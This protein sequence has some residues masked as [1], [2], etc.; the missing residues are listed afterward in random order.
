[1]RA[2]A[3]IRSVSVVPWSKALSLLPRKPSAIVPLDFDEEPAPE[4][5][6]DSSGAEDIPKGLFRD[7]G[8]CVRAEKGKVVSCDLE[9]EPEEELRPVQCGLQC[10]LSRRLS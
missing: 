10:K 5:E 3:A 8:N 1:M 2:F 7:I 6:Q 4:T 9:N